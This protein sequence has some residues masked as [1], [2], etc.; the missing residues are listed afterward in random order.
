MSVLD[1]NGII[2]PKDAGLSRRKVGVA[3]AS[4]GTDYE[5]GFKMPEH[6]PYARSL[7]NGQWWVLPWS[8]LV[9]LATEEGI[10]EAQ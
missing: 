5:I 3:H 10:D 9:E 8:N 1:K 7:E 2:Y 6:A 4:D